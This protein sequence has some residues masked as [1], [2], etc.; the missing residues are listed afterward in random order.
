MSAVKACAPEFDLNELDE[1]ERQSFLNLVY[2]FR[3]EL[4]VLL[5]GRARAMDLFSTSQMR[6]LRAYGVVGRGNDGISTVM[7]TA[8]AVL[9]ADIVGDMVRGAGAP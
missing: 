3:S 6:R 1:F 9:D 5:S 4:R 2:F 8:Q 7:P